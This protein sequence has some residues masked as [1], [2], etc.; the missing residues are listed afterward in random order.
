MPMCYRLQH[1]PPTAHC[2]CHLRRFLS[3]K[4]AHLD[5]QMKPSEQSPLTADTEGVS[6][7]MSHA[8]LLV[9]TDCDHTTFHFNPLTL[10]SYTLSGGVSSSSKTLPGH[11]DQQGFARKMSKHQT[12]LLNASLCFLVETSLGA[13]E[14]LC[15]LESPTQRSKSP[16]NVHLKTSPRACVKTADGHISSSRTR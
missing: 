16:S 14:I 15:L 10:A 8:M 9:P 4:V 2:F 3:V 12:R 6:S 13:C 11:A 5:A 7:S 1:W